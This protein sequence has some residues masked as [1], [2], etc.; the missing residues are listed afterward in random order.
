MD[1]NIVLIEEI[2]PE[3]AGN[4]AISLLW[5]DNGSLCGFG[6]ANAGNTCGAWCK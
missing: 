6:C 1:D 2:V 3:S 5:W 4:N